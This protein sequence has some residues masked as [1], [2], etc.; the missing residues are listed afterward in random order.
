MKEIDVTHLAY[1]LN[2]AKNNNQPRPIFFLGAGASRTGGI[3]LAR[4][5]KEQILNRYS[6]NP[7]LKGLKEEEQSYA[8]LMARLQ[9]AQRDDLLKQ[10]I[11]DA[12]INVT[13]IYL[14]QL[15][16]NDYVDY[17]LTVNF[18]NLM[19]R[20]LALYNIFPATYD[21]AILKDLTTSTFKEKS[22]VYLH[23]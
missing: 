19:L 23:G 7:F 18:D 13:H 5:I 16:K 21:M 22:V 10:Y 2:E 15:L 8:S 14:A 20:A 12:R 1:L 11:N 9:P 4:E 3:P 17:I 6:N